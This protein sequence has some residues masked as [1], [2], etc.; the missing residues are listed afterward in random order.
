MSAVKEKNRQKIMHA[1]KGL[2]E[3]Y[4]VENVSFSQVA[5]EAGVCRTTVFNY[6]GGTKELMLGIF[7]QEIDDLTEY[8][9]KSGLRGKEKVLALFDKLIDDTAAY[10]ILATQLIQNAILSREPK[11]PIAAIEHTVCGA[12][13]DDE[14]LGISVI[15]TYLGLISH[16]HINGLLF[17]GDKMKADFRKSFEILICKYEEVNI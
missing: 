2:F 6:F 9:D 17:D 15:G 14:T 10:P 11:N 3:R 1:A 4:G 16:Y 7:S 12:L 8:F 13:D 5:E